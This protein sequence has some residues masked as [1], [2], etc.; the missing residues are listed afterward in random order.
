MAYAFR[1]S[2]TYLPTLPIRA[3]DVKPTVEAQP[4][5]WVMC[6]QINQ[7]F[8]GVRCMQNRGKFKALN[9]CAPTLPIR[10]KDVKPTVEA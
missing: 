1:E 4:K 3:K 5:R 7:P 9:I 6:K 2:H 10:A 8:G